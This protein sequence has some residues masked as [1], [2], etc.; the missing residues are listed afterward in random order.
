MTSIWGCGCFRREHPFLTS[1]FIPSIASFAS[2]PPL[3]L[4]DK[5]SDQPAKSSGIKS[6]TNALATAT[7]VFKY[8]E[9]DLQ[10]IF[11]A[12]LEAQAPAP[13]L[14][15]TL[16]SALAPTLA[17]A[18]APTLTPALTS[19][20]ASALVPTLAPALAPAPAPVSASVV[21]ERP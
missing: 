19:T 6:L 9:N 7:C 12:V 18:F 11:K 17:L 21:F 20:I 16:A 8:S 3:K 14:A 15:L 1:S 5:L 2:S 4:G 13:T 10:R